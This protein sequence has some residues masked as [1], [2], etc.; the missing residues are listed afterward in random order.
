MDAVEKKS[1]GDGAAAFGEPR[2]TFVCGSRRVRVDSRTLRRERVG[3]RSGGKG[4]KVTCGYDD[5]RLG[6]YLLAD[7]TTSNCTHEVQ[8]CFYLHL[9]TN[10]VCHAYGVVGDT[11]EGC[12]VSAT[13]Q[14]P[15]ASHS[16]HC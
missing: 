9:P 8:K 3:R 13:Q 6:G 16:I 2:F 4:L 1:W 5:D 11:A 7:K 14:V 10:G 12:H 15:V